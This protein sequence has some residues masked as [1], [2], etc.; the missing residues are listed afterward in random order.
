ML[1]AEMTVGLGESVL[2]EDTGNSVRL[3]LN[4]FMHT[5]WIITCLLLLSQTTSALII[6]AETGPAVT[7]GI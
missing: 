3:Q 4:S 2:P 7:P 5:V 1:V 6:C